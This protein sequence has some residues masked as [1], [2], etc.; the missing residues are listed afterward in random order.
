M[1]RGDIGLRA[2]DLLLDRGM[3]FTVSD[4]PFY[5]KMF[6]LHRFR[7]RPL[8]A[9]TIMEISR[10]IDKEGLSDIKDEAAA[11]SRMDK[12]ALVIAMAILNR[13][14]AIGRLKGILA[15]ALLWKIPASTLYRIYLTIARINSISDF[16]TITGFFA[17]QSAMMMKPKIPGQRGK[18]S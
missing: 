16:M 9:G 1:D 13:R 2:A 5:L 14:L 18:G 15:A 10:T 4:A 3:R 17:L 12:I 7:I 8:R 6:G 11:N